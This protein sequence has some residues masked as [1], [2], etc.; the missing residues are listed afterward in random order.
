MAEVAQDIVSSSSSSALRGLHPS[1]G[2]REP[3]PDP[4]AGLPSPFSQRTTLPY[5]D[6]TVVSYIVGLLEDEDEE[7]AEIIDMSRGMLEGGPDGDDK[8]AELE[9]L[10]VL[11]FLSLPSFEFVASVLTG[12]S[13]APRC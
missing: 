9:A 1:Q 7:E 4:S 12:P 5:T 8:V 13:C 2:P 11:L 10:C 3:T 6:E